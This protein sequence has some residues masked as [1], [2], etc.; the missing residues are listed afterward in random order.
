[1]QIAVAEM[2]L[3]ALGHQR[4]PLDQRG[5]DR[6]RHPTDLAGEPV[7]LARQRDRRSDL[8]ERE[9]QL[10]K[11]STQ[12]S[13]L[14]TADEDVVPHR[15]PHDVLVHADQSTL[16]LDDVDHLWRRGPRGADRRRVQRL[17]ADPRVRG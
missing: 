12:V 4:Q 8:E 2:G 15:R 13:D 14:A 16:E 10:G 7:L 17:M 5:V 11:P 9:M 6:L 3:L 1:M